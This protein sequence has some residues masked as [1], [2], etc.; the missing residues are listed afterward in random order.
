MTGRGGKT[1]GP[2]KL[3]GALWH[4]YRRKVGDWGEAPSARGRRGGRRLGFGD[5][6][7]AS[8]LGSAAPSR[9]D[10]QYQRRFVSRE[11]ET[12]VPGHSAR[13][14]GPSAEWRRSGETSSSPSRSARSPR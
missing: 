5:P 13:R 8:D 9:D 11:G 14:D 1:L 2:E 7:I 6:V 3:D 12:G 4:A 10:D